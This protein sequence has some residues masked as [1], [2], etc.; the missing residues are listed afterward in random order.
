MDEQETS[1]PG[2]DS[3]PL[4]SVV[5][6]V[7]ACA[8]GVLQI[9]QSE[10]RIASAETTASTRWRKWPPTPTRTARQRVTF[11]NVPVLQRVPIPSLVA[12][13]GAAFS[14]GSS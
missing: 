5:A 8:D 3:R 6:V 2:A 1:D 10:V 9:V 11:V 14:A 13:I 7:G 4:S 12:E